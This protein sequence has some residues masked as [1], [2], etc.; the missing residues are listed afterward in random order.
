VRRLAAALALLAPLC[1]KTYTYTYWIEPCTPN[2]STCHTE[3][4][5]L[6]QWALNAWQ[7]N[8]G[9]TLKFERT[10]QRDRALLRFHWATGRDGLYGEARPII[11]NGERGAEIH[12]RPDLT[13]LG[14][15]ISAIGRKDPLFREA[16]VYLTCLHESGHALGLPHTAE[17]DD[18]MYSFQYGGDI[19]E[20]FQRYR[21]RLSRR[22]DIRNH[23]GISPDDQRRLR[24]I[25]Q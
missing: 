2:G 15:E 23:P 14:P 17:F 13:H 8:S 19:V 24:A 5:D 16:I 7:S 18:I 10:T 22:A 11:V 12:V 3:D 4:A 9:G 6:A 21:R 1:A 25:F 20:Y